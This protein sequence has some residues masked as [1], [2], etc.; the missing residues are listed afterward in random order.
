MFGMDPEDNR[1]V[2]GLSYIVEK[3]TKL[4]TTYLHVNKDTDL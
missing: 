3:I 4:A 1:N 2:V